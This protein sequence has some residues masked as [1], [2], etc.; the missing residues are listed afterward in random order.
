MPE[1]N[2]RAALVQI[3]TFTRKHINII[4]KLNTD[5]RIETMCPGKSLFPTQCIVH[6]RTC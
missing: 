2:E 3:R 6:V 1:G 5:L 4:C